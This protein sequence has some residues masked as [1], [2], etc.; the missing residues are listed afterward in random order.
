[1]KP[2]WWF[3]D[4]ETIRERVGS[5][6]LPYWSCIELRG[7]DRDSLLN[8]LA[9]N[10]LDDMPPGDGRETFLAD[11]KGHVV[12]HGMVLAD[13]DVTRF[14]TAA[15]RADTIV[16][17]LQK[18]VVR[19]HVQ[20]AD[21]S[22]RTALWYCGGH[23]AE[24]LL[25]NN[26]MAVPQE[27][28]QHAS[29]NWEGAPVKACRVDMVGPIGFLLMVPREH[30]RLVAAFLQRLKVK[31]C[32]R[33]AFDSA[34]IQWGWPL[35]RID[36]SGENFPQEVGRDE[37]AISFNKG[38]YLGQETIARIESL[39]HVN[40]RLVL[41]RF[42][43]AQDPLSA[44][45]SFQGK[46]IG[47]TTSIGYSPE[48]SCP[49]ALASVRREWSAPGTILDSSLGPAETVPLQRLSSVSQH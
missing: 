13:E 34:R 39:G 42:P 10:R 36:I 9:T 17:H 1:M 25:E 31:T 14:V 35:D 37:Q 16:E 29:A 23:R 28:G 19:E 38:C 32:V 7:S 47:S 21:R 24:E 20:I 40:K 44:D 8:S 41:V 3:K 49:V 45:L 43:D 33:Q 5:I 27:P 46:L 48:F 11:A 2:I 30:A 18:Y 22:V 12:A 6:E 4:Y 15:P 26:G